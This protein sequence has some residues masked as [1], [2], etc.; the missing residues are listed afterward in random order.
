MFF[1][2]TK[3]YEQPKIQI[4]KNKKIS[5]KFLLKKKS[6]SLQKKSKQKSQKS[7]PIKKQDSKIK[8]SNNNCL[9]KLVQHEK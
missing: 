3:S 2:I 1:A 9:S 5:F 6:L 8:Q 4:I 7:K